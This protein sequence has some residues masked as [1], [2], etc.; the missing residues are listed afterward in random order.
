MSGVKYIA[1]LVALCAAIP[2]VKYGTL[3]PCSI[4]RANVRE[5]L[6]HS[7]GLVGL[8]AL[9][10]D[11]VLDAGIESQFGG[12]LTPGHCVVVLLTGDTMNA[13][14]PAATRPQNIRQP[15]PSIQA[16]MP[17][18]APPIQ[19]QQPSFEERMK[20]AGEEAKAAVNECRDRR[21]AGELKT[22]V[23]S[24][25]C[26]NPRYEEAYRKAGYPYMDLIVQL[27]AKRIEVAE[28]TDAGKLTEGQAQLELAR[29]FS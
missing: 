26:S 5:Q 2:L 6:K 8:A 29:F 10:P 14:I 13:Q 19:P 12:E 1:I 9:L 21:L 3:S 20:R 18:Q 17:V 28:R 23:E 15:E 4:L 7:G 24:A 25:N 22:H 27:E 11:S 16:P